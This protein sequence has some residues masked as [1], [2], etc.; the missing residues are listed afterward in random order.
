MDLKPRLSW[1]AQV[2]SCYPLEP[3]FLFHVQHI[4]KLT[5]QALV[6]TCE[7]K[8]LAYGCMNLESSLA[9]LSSSKNTSLLMAPRWHTSSCRPKKPGSPRSEEPSLTPCF[10][11]LLLRPL[12]PLPGAVFS[13]TVSHLPSTSLSSDVSY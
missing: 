5:P 3:S 9:I 12:R 10:F 6:T 8:W 7:H 11:P 13:G 2:G 1:P 4:C